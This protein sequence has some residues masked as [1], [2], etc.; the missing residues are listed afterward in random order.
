MNMS[1]MVSGSALCIGVLSALVLIGCGGTTVWPNPTANIAA[2]N[3]PLVAQYNAF[4]P[5][6]YTTAWV[7]F[8]EDTTY[9][10]E[11]NTTAPTSSSGQA[12]QILVAGMKAS[13]TYHMRGHFDW[14]GGSWVSPD[15][16]FTTGAI[17]KQFVK[18]TLTVTRPNPNLTP[19]PGIELLDLAAQNDAHILE[20]LFTDLQGNIIWYYDVGQGNYPSPLKPV[21]NGHMLVIVSSGFDGFALQEIDLAGNV[22]RQINPAQVNQG[23]KA[24]GYSFTVTQFHHDVALLPNGHWIVLANVVKAY[25]D[26]PGYPGTTNVEGD[27]LIDLD[28]DWNV[29]WAWNSFDHLDVT[30]A[31]FGQPDWTH[32][33]AIIYLPNDG[34]LLLSMR[35]QSWVLKIDYNN[36]QGTGDIIWHL[37]YQGDFAIAG[38]DPINWFYGQHFPNPLSVNGNQMTMAV[39]DDGNNRVLGT[40]GVVC[41]YPGAPACYSRAAIFQIDES[42]KVATSSWQ[43]LPGLFTFW[44]GSIGQLA[45]NNNVEFDMSEPYLPQ[46]PSGSIVTEVTQT[47]N[48]QVVWQMRMDGANAYRAYRVPS[49]YP[50]VTWQK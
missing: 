6:V 36:G 41:G 23:L 5:H 30:R 19:S 27:A 39:F 24:A 49:L 13:T 44:G 16:T 37:G 1:R 45:P 47:A 31:P 18:P 46:D 28:A 35:N 38:G 14:P 32:S 25:T 42:S 20:A 26:L 11:T 21:G 12:I 3:N 29:V 43:Y 4:A 40:D 2:T 9:G 34:N 48:P 17:P 15:Q 10:R 33:N 22:I 7:E 50:G 8:G